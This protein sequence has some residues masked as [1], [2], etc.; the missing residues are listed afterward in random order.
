MAWR[1]GAAV[2]LPRPPA[3]L[4]AAVWSRRGTR[5]HSL[6]L[7]SEL[8]EAGCHRGSQKLEVRPGVGEGGG[9]LR[10]PSPSAP[11]PAKPQVPPRL[12]GEDWGW[13]RRGGGLLARE[14]SR[15]TQVGQHGDCYQN[16]G[17]RGASELLPPL[18]RLCTAQSQRVP[19]ADLLSVLWPRASHPLLHQPG[20]CLRF[21][22]SG[23]L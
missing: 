14:V 7:F 13:A 6:A 10:L 21:W 1:C 3:L 22:S 11:G 8:W 17:P 5:E 2:L 12:G 16:C 9:C 19:W 23:R 4:P 15:V 20:L 18:L